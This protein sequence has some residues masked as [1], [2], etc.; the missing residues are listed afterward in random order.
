VIFLN[1]AASCRFLSIQVISNTRFP[2]ETDSNQHPCCSRLPAQSCR[3]LLLLASRKK[4]RTSH[5]S[6]LLPDFGTIASPQK[7]KQISQ[8]VKEI[9]PKT[10]HSSRT[11]SKEKSRFQQCLNSLSVSQT[12]IRI[13]PKNYIPR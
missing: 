4:A 11:T 2:R 9:F 12:T 6:R 10:N 13:S 5:L 3:S 7:P 8:A 1:E